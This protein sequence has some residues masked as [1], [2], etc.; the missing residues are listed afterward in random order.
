MTGAEMT[1]LTLRPIPIHSSHS[2]KKKS[3]MLQVQSIPMVFWLLLVM[4]VARCV[5]M[6]SSRKCIEMEEIGAAH[7]VY[8]QTSKSVESV[9][10]SGIGRKE[11]ANYILGRDASESKRLS[12]QHEVLLKAAGGYF[13]VPLSV[14]NEKLEAILDV[15]TGNGA[16]LTGLRQSGKI[17]TS[18]E[19]CGVDVSAKMMPNQALCHKS[20]LDLRVQ[21]LSEPLPSSWDGK[22]DYIHGRHVFIWIKPSNWPGVI[23]NL[24][25]SLKPGG[26]LVIVYPG[27]TGYDLKTEKPLAHN[28]APYRIFTAFLKYTA[29]LGFPREAVATLPNLLVEA[30]F[31]SKSIVT[32]T[33]RINL[34]SAEPDPELRSAATHHLDFLLQ[35]MQDIEH[36]PEDNLPAVGDQLGWEKVL[37]GWREATD[38]GFFYDLCIVSARK[39]E[40][41][42][43]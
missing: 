3:V 13:P 10:M 21:D 20:G 32:T 28:S 2:R 35:L 26:T 30:G 43:S 37:Q 11:S 40:K 31:E 9:E 7:H 15:G 36:S 22:F 4:L 17:P 12:D 27:T 23:S 19:L 14:E 39:P 38:A 8:D 6:E 5:G 16:W 33:K 18:V 25:R 42:I 24:E 1:V 29:S 41:L 34:G